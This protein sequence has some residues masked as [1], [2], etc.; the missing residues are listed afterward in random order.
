MKKMKF[1]ILFVVLLLAGYCFFN[2]TQNFSV[3][4]A[5]YRL[6]QAM[7]AQESELAAQSVLNQ[8]KK[9][10]SAFLSIAPEKSAEEN[11]KNL[12]L[13]SLALNSKNASVQEAAIPYARSLAIDAA[14]GKSPADEKNR[15][16]LNEILK[17]YR[18]VAQREL[19]ERRFGFPN[20][21]MLKY[22]S[23]L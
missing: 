21:P 16:A 8:K 22:L 10:R 11:L 19:A 15:Q 6:K 20:S 13:V 7:Q 3:V 23:S 5:H 14:Y 1:I 12:A 9:V 18:E 4:P 17:T 2:V